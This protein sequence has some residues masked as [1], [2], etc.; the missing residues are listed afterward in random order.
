MPGR[1]RG[2]GR[3]TT[4]QPIQEPD[5]MEDA[6]QS[7]SSSPHDFRTRS[8]LTFWVGREPCFA[9][10]AGDAGVSQ[11]WDW[12]DGQGQRQEGQAGLQDERGG[13]GANDHL[14]GAK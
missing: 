7:A 3:R 12:E 9:G 11:P 5:A 8:R 4:G 13:Q 6:T 14:P 10:F 2:R 1:G